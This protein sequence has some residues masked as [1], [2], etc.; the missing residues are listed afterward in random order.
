MFLSFIVPVYNTEKYLTECLD[1]L[2]DQDI[3]HEEYEIICVNDGSTDGSLKILREY[4]KT[5]ANIRVINQPNGGV[6]VARNTG[7]DAAEGGYI[8]FVDS[9]DFILRKCLGELR[10]KAGETGADRITVGVYT[11]REELTEQERFAAR[12]NKL[13][14]NAHFHDTTVWDSILLREFLMAHNCK[15]HYPD[16]THSEDTLYMHELLEHGP[17]IA[18]CDSTMY[19]YRNRPGSAM[20]ATGREKYQKFLLSHMCYCEMVFRS[21]HRGA[22]DTIKTANLCMD[23]LWQTLWFS[24]KL[25]FRERRKILR[26]LKSEGIWPIKR[27]PECTLRKSYQTTRTDFVGKLFD[28]LYITQHTRLGFSLMCLWRMAEKVKYKLEG[29]Q[30]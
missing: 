21:Y 26:K 5:H 4:E 16:M 30:A 13:I 11:F 12:S 22:R 19:F 24:T 17:N 29:R 20:T 7:L 9:D 27:L 15:F 10:A 2:L 25:P 1:S 6:C 23:A 3:P 18:V 8:W 14:P 28:Q